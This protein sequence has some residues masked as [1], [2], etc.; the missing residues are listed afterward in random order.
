MLRTVQLMTE[1]PA[2]T[3]AGSLTS[4]RGCLRFSSIEVGLGWR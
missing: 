4:L 3:Y 1:P 2:E